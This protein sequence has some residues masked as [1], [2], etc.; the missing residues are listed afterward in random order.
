VVV[1]VDQDV[2]FQEQMVVQGV[3]LEVLVLEVV[4][5]VEDQEIHRLLVQLREK[6]VEMEVE[7]LLFLE[8]WEVVEQ[9]YKEVHKMLTYHQCPVLLMEETEVQLS[10]LVQEV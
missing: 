9:Q 7:V 5:A 4:L 3:E 6:M 10:L 1:E 8:E 2:G